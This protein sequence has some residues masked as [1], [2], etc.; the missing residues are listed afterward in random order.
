VLRQVQEH[1]VDLPICGEVAPGFEPVRDAF[2]SNFTE[3][4]DAGAGVCIYLNGMPV[5]DLAGGWSWKSAGVPYDKSCLQLVFSSTKGATAICAHILAERGLLDYGDPVANYW[6]QF[7][8]NGKASV[9]V[10]QILSHQ[11]GLP[12]ISEPMDLDLVLQWDPIVEALANQEPFWEPGSAH[13]YHALTFGWLVGEIVR[14]VSG[15]S[16]GEFFAQEVARPLGLEFWIGLPE[17]QEQRVSKLR[18]GPLPDFRH[19]DPEMKKIAADIFAPGSL[20]LRALTLNGSFGQFMG[21]EGP[22]NKRE[23]HAAEV[24]AANGIT[25]ARSLARMY[26]A[27]VGPVDGV[28]LINSS[29]VASATQ[30]QSEGPDRVLTAPSR[31]GLGFMLDRKDFAPLL[32]PASFGHSGAGGSL[33]FADPVHNVGFGYVMNQMRLGLAGDERP[34][35]LIR[36]LEGCLK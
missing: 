14:R 30:V 2:I 22:F 21:G 13:G 4:G 25:N 8:N 28:R 23:V 35:R 34:V 20:M 10:A 11:A 27:T 33:G 9:T 31:F 16:I 6:P 15:K 36:A 12:T 32:S 5:V 19:L 26:A 7:A 3:L 24:P 1:L 29:T 17:D 18:L